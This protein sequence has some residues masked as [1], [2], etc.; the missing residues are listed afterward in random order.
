MKLGL[1][2]FYF[3]STTTI[4]FRNN[5]SFNCK[6][7][8]CRVS[9]TFFQNAFFKEIKKALASSNM[10]FQK[11]TI[12]NAYNLFFCFLSSTPEYLV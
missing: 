12:K 7:I 8:L 3:Y 10:I 9:K 4:K 6:N 2:W 5:Q 11:T 1:I